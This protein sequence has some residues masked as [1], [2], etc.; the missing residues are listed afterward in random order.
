MVSPKIVLWDVEITGVTVSTW[1]LYPESIPYQ[2]ILQDWSMISVCWKELGKK[3]IYSSSIIDDPKR[4]AKNHKDDYHVIKT[5][6]DALDDVDILVAHNAK[7]DLKAFNTRLIVHDLPPLPK[8]QQ[9][10]TLREIKK[11]AKF[12]SNRL[13]YLASTLGNS[14]KMETSPGLWL[15]ASNGD[16]K[17]IEEMVKYNKVDVKILED[18]YLRIRKYMTSHPNLAEPSSPNCPNVS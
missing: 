10:D 1:N 15:R 9:I 2:N 8:I 18:L 4:F 5:V 6:R 16:K 3:R 12:T 11:V 13:D 14:G 7:F 17:A